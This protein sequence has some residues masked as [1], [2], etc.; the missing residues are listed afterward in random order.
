DLA[1][2][3]DVAIGAGGAAG[4]PVALAN[5]RCRNGAVTFA[6]SA[7]QTVT[8]SESRFDNCAVTTAGSGPIA[9]TGSCFAAGSLAGTPAA[10][11]VLTDCFA[12]GAG[13]N[14]Q[15]TSPVPVQQLGSMSIAPENVLAGGSVTFHADLPPGLVGLFVLGFTPGAPLLAPPFRVYVDPTNY[16]LWPGAYALQQ[17][18]TWQVPAG[19]QFVGI[20]LT[21]QM[22]VLPGAGMQAP[23]LQMPPGRRFVLQ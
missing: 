10:P 9:V 13:A 21:V 7:A 1:S 5:W 4:Q 14:V 20:D 19:V 22:V 12:P 18:A 15:V 23:W 3:G 2:V 17:T 8:V 6:T 16:V 11:F